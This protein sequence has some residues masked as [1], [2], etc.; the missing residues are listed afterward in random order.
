MNE[1]G[2]DERPQNRTDATFSGRSMVEMLGVLAIIGVLSVGAISGYSKAMMKYKLNKQAEQISDLIVNA[3]TSAPEFKPLSSNGSYSLIPYYIK[4]NFV[5]ENMILPNTDE[6]LQDV[7]KNNISAGYLNVSASRRTY[8]EM[9]IAFSGA[10]D[11]LSNMAQCLNLVNIFKEH[12]AF[13][14]TIFSQSIISEG[15]RYQNLQGD[16]NCKEGDVCLHSL[17]IAQSEAFCS[18]CFAHETASS[19]CRIA[20]DFN[21]NKY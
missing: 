19:Y 15:N 16:G 6:Q 3:L 1:N 4:L 8:I 10:N 14:H 12:H 7:F 9:S 18:N 11:K 17:T 21:Y 2:R 20:I 5:P 13:I